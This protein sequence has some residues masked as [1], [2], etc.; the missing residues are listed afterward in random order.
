MKKAVQPA[1]ILLNQLTGMKSDLKAEKL[2]EAFRQV[3]PLDKCISDL[4]AAVEDAN[5]DFSEEIVDIVGQRVTAAKCVMK[6]MRAF[7]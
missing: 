4:R 7:V 1:M 3:N 5:K 6:S 2:P